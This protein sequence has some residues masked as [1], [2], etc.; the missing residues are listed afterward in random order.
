M[1]H[2]DDWVK[3]LK[4]AFSEQ[5]VTVTVDKDLLVLTVPPVH[6]HVVA[7][8]LN[9]AAIFAFE[10]LTDACAVDYLTHGQ[11]EWLT[12]ET[13]NTGFSR[14]RE[15]VDTKTSAHPNRFAMVYHLLSFSHNRRLRVVCWLTDDDAPMIDS[16]TDIWPS[17]N[18]YEREAF[19]LMGVFFHH[20]PDLRRLLTDYG[21]EGYPLRKDF[22][23]TG[24]V[25]V[26]YD[27][28]A[29]RVIYEPVDVET[30]VSTPKVIRQEGEPCQK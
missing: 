15:A 27:A 8:R 7:K 21:F 5:A 19:D 25:Q 24:H 4:E 1:I 26:R 14:A 17:A 22:P 2:M 18:W 20:H 16:I 11:S 23:L 3:N 12:Q 6:W 28:T 9:T 29:S 13:T 30:R 10:Q